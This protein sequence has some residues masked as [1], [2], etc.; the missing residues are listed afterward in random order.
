MLIRLISRARDRDLQYV[1]VCMNTIYNKNT[2]GMHQN[3]QM[4]ENNP[5]LPIKENV[6]INIR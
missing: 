2:S 5:K 6:K 4:G 3:K 1:T